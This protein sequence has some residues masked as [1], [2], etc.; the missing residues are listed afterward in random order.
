[1]EN[2][3]ITLGVHIDHLDTLLD[4]TRHLGLTLLTEDVATFVRQTMVLP[5][6]PSSPGGAP[7]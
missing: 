3:G 7:R 4:M 6:V 5:A 1:M 2:P